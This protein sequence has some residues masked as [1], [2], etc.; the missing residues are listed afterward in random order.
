MATFNESQ[1]E[2]A[3]V[4]LFKKQGYAYVHG[5]TIARDTRD[6]ILYDDLR[7]FL[8][9]RYKADGITEN[10]IS[11]AINHLET[12][13]GGSVYA[14]NVEAM[15]LI[16]KGFAIKREDTS[17]PNLYI[18]L[19]DYKDIKNNIFKFVNQFEIVENHNRI[20]DG[21]VFVN[22]IPLVVLEFKNAIRENTTPTAPV[23]LLLWREDS[24]PCSQ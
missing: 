12:T 10:E 17:K 11:A 15:R 21:I 4:E 7:S 6:V 13:E 8:R 1:L 14:Q 9:E 24:T 23:A 2:Q 5:E 22:G 3:F 16:M 20:P 19:I 18:N